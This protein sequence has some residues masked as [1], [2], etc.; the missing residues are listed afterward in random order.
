MDSPYSPTEPLEFDILPPLAVPIVLDASDIVGVDVAPAPI[1]PPPPPLAV[2][3]EPNEEFPPVAPA[4][5]DPVPLAPM[6]TVTPAKPEVKRPIDRPPALPP[7]PHE[8]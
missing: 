1:A 8:I 5:L 4:P 7:P 6:V 3:A 2:S